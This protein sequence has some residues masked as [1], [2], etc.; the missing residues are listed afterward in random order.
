MINTLND[1]LKFEQILL[2]K[3][4]NDKETSEMLRNNNLCIYKLE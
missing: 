1:V 3:P 2:Y 4:E